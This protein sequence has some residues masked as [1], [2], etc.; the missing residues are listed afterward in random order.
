MLASLVEREY[1]YTVPRYQTL[2]RDKGR[3]G[4]FLLPTPVKALHLG[5]DT[6]LAKQKSG[7]Y[8]ATTP[9]LHPTS[10]WVLLFLVVYLVT[11]PRDASHSAELGHP[12][13][14]WIL[15]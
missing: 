15:N 11:A 5:E 4:H 12:P 14:F 9:S 13:L 1:V 6:S 2:T 10:D 3:R 7:H 8:D